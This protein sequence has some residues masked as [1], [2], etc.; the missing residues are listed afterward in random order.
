MYAGAGSVGTL[1][2]GLAA[3]GARIRLLLGNGHAL[4]TVSTRQA[5]QQKGPLGQGQTSA[6]ALRVSLLVAV[7]AGAA[8]EGL[9]TLCALVWPLSLVDALV[10]QQAR[11][12][13]ESLADLSHTYS[14]W[15]GGGTGARTRGQAARNLTHLLLLMGASELLC[16]LP[17]VLQGQRGPP[18]KRPHYM[19]LRQAAPLGGSAGGGSD[20]G[21]SG[22]CLPDG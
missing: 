10:L 7:E 18:G 1:V 3:L 14:P 13:R 6:V 11:G 8:H 9:A 16:H 19:G 15:A 12:A 21:S 22:I 4:A 2:E 17:L 20:A 5:P